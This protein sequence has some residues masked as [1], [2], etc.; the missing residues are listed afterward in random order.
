MHIDIVKEFYYNKKYQQIVEQLDDFSII[1]LLAIDEIVDLAFDVGDEKTRSIAKTMKDSV[2]YKNN[3]TLGYKKITILQRHAIAKYLLEKYKT[4][5]SIIACAYNVNE[6]ELF[7]DEENFID[8]KEKIYNEAKESGC[9]AASVG[10]MKF[11][12]LTKNKAGHIV[13][14]KIREILK[15]TASHPEIFSVMINDEIIWI[16]YSEAKKFNLEEVET[17]IYKY[18]EVILA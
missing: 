12:Y 14:K 7:N 13:S 6:E 11:V 16:T 17:P 15:T 5:K 4:A 2:G 8:T 1:K 9:F 3:S 10:T 18:E